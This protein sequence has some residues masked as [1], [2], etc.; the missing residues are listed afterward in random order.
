[1]CRDAQRG[2]RQ[3]STRERL[4]VRTLKIAEPSHTSGNIPKVSSSQP[5]MGG[6]VALATEGGKVA[7]DRYHERQNAQVS[8]RDLLFTLPAASRPVSAND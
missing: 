4:L 5:L 3:A 8:V 7:P 1:M 2:V 6:D